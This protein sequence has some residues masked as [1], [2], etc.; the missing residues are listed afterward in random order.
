MAQE[1]EKFLSRWS[2]LK[3]EQ[4]LPEDACGGVGV[5]ARGA[6]VLSGPLSQAAASANATTASTKRI[7]LLLVACPMR[8]CKRRAVV[9]VGLHWSL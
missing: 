8:S 9:A 6:G 3:Q 5:S 7:E 1:K 2:R 4:K